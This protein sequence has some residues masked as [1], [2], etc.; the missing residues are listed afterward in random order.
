MGL[1][2]RSSYLPDCKGHIVWTAASLATSLSATRECC[3]CQCGPASR[4][5]RSFTYLSRRAVCVR[6][7][8]QLSSFYNLQHKKG[9]SGHLSNFPLQNGQFCGDV[10]H[11][12][13]H[14]VRLK[15]DS[16][17]EGAVKLH[18]F[19]QTNVKFEPLSLLLTSTQSL[20][21]HA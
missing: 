20:H 10:S 15:M 18:P 2:G 5:F 12:S 9:G 7:K 3:C 1:H 8:L 13:K 4:A 19:S 6:D 11:I 17:L 21:S 14:V 16:H